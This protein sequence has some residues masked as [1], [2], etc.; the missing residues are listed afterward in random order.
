[1]RIVSPE[2]CVFYVFSPSTEPANTQS[3]SVEGVSK[4][5]NKNEEA[6]TMNVYDLEEVSLLLNLLEEESSHWRKFMTLLIV[7]GLCRGEGLGLE[8]KHIDLDNGVI[9]ISQTIVHT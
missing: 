2:Y 3:L 6:E 4:S 9:D 7:A 1:M 5:R 8:W